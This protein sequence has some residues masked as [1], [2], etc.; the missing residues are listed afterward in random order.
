MSMTSIE[1]LKKMLEALPETVQDRAVEHL[2]EYLEEITDDLRWDEQYTAS[3]KELSDVARK[4]RSEIAD[5]ETE[6][7]DL[8]RL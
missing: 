1:T 7:M 2:R 3:S 4:V 6:P 5:G 8:G